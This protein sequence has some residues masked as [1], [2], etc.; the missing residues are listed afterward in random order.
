[1]LELLMRTRDD[2]RGSHPCSGAGGRALRPGPA[3]LAKWVACCCCCMVQG[4]PAVRHRNL[5][6]RSPPPGWVGAG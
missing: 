6:L 1:M 4:S 5:P 3:E 2:G